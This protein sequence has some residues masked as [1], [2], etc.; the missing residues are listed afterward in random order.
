MRAG[1]RLRELQGAGAQVLYAAVLQDLIERDRR[2]MER[3]TAPLKPASDAI[4][5]DS[6]AMDADQA[7]AAALT[8][9]TRRLG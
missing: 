7:F 1:R 3:A 5:L 9:V 2:D 6:S 8:L 4:V